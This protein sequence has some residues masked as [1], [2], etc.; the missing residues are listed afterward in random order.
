MSRDAVQRLAH[1]EALSH[2]VLETAPDAFIGV[3]MEG[4]IVT[5]NAKATQTFGWTAEEAIGCTLWDKIIPPVHGDAWEHFRE[6]GE[7]PIANLRMEVTARHRSG[8]EFPVEVTISG[9]IQSDQGEFFGAFLRD[10]SDRREREQEL[11]K[12]KDAAEAQAKTLHLL[13]GISRELNSVLNTDQLLRRIGELLAE[14]I[15]YQ[16]F[17]ILLLDASGQY[18]K[19]RFSLS[20]SQVIAK[21]DIPIDRGLVGYAARYR[22]PVVVPNVRAD[23]R[24]IKFHEETCSELSVPLITKEKLIGVLDIENATCDYFRPSHVEAVMLLASQLAVALENAMLYDRVSKQ[25]RQLNQDLNFAREL[26]KRLQPSG[27]PPMVNAKVASLCRP[28][29]I[30][31]GDMFDFGFYAKSRLNVGVLGDVSGKGAPA[32]LYAALT[33]GVIRSLMERELGPAQ[34]LS[35]VNQALMER[36]LDDRYIALMYGVWDDQ[37][38]ILRIANSGLPRPVY[39][40]NGKMQ[41]IDAIGIPLGMFPKPEFDEC[42]VEAVPGD[43]F[44]FLTDGILEA[45]DRHDDEF[46]YEGIQAALRNTSGL[47]AAEIRE[48][49]L[50]S[51]ASHCENLEASDDQTMIVFRVAGS[52]TNG[53]RT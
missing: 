33:S 37:R 53:A 9:P 12:A 41:I 49:L 47:N 45:R 40:R 27:T 28:A 48:V 26:Q 2:L 42:V 17:S 5:W 50:Q 22:Q 44:L 7:S 11:R 38:L 4:C 34:M 6:T 25:E 23:S 30:I 15:E 14:L 16:T 21:P 8:R 31:A 19:H 46:G 3:D 13:N 32:A 20:D 52:A 24:Y 39:F 1:S 51:L 35:A 36:P 18:L 29:R 43:I 10:V